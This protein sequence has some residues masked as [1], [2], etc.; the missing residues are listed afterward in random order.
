[1][2]YIHKDSRI[3]P[4]DVRRRGREGRFKQGNP[5]FAHKLLAIVLLMHH[6]KK[7]D[8]HAKL[9]AN[10][11]RITWKRY[12]LFL[13]MPWYSACA[14]SIWTCVRERKYSQTSFTD[15]NSVKG[16]KCNKMTRNR[17]FI[18]DWLFIWLR[19]HRKERGRLEPFIAVGISLHS[20][21]LSRS[22][23][24]TSSTSAFDADKSWNQH[25]S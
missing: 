15:H 4:K 22:I 24:L 23:V 8:A 17:A 3:S 2:Q 11:R 16:G 18:Q 10:K 12:I 19:N 7:R 21:S 9:E 13:R 14:Q 6:P 25:W 5:F 1:M 20:L